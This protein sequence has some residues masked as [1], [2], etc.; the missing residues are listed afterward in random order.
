[1][2]LTSTSSEVS[3]SKLGLGT[4]FSWAKATRPSRR[5]PWPWPRFAPE[6]GSKSCSVGCFL[7][8]CRGV[9][10]HRLH[11][12]TAVVGRNV[13]IQTVAQVSDGPLDPQF[14]NHLVGL[15]TNDA[16]IGIEH[17]RV[18][19][20]LQ[21]FGATSSA[22][23]LTRPTAVGLPIQ[24]E[25]GAWQGDSLQRS[26]CRPWRTRSQAPAFKDSHTI[27]CGQ[28][29]LHVQLPAQRTRPAVKELNEMHPCVD[30]GMQVRLCGFGDGGEQRV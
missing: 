12:R 20:S 25:R 17:T 14:V 3:N 28:H 8:R 4:K 29:P 15:L 9:F 19:I 7:F 6:R 23:H 10:L 24:S 2:S 21:H 16:R 5:T 26:G 13:R 27:A 30:L 18:Q 11:K 1:M 22:G